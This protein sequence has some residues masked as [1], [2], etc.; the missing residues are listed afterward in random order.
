MNCGTN[1]ESGEGVGGVS[2]SQW[3]ALRVQR[4]ARDAYLKSRGETQ[5]VL[6]FRKLDA[7]ADALAEEL[8]EWDR[9]QGRKR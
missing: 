1:R 9:Q 2:E 7:D 4:E 5:K 6:E 3:E 8:A